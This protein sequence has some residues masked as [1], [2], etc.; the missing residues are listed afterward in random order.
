MRRWQK[1]YD[2]ISSKGCEAF[3]VSKP[4]NVRYLCGYRGDDSL[5]ILLEEGMYLFTDFRYLEDAEESCYGKCQVM[6][7]PQDR[8]TLGYVLDWLKDRSVGKV[9]FESRWTVYE[10]YEILNSKF[11]AIPI[12]DSVERLRKIKNEDEID[13]IRKAGEIALRGYRWLLDKISPGVSERELEIHLEA[14]LKEIGAEERAFPFIIA[15]GPNAAKPHARPSARKIAES[16]AVI[17]DFGVVWDGYHV[18]M[19]RTFIVGKPSS[20]LKEIYNA[21]RGAQEAVLERVKPGVRVSELHALAEKYLGKWGP[22]FKH[23]LGHGVGLEIHESPRISKS[24]EEILEEGMVITIEPGVY[25]RG[26][27]GV[28][29]EDTIVVRAEGAEILTPAPKEGII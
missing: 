14:F 7:I 27:L 3:L 6:E 10:T 25:L 1:V 22:Y 5:L 2:F 18:D 26:E 24:S 8:K 28:R 19:T 4:V 11:N 29:I 17:C 21:V 23:S 9:G 20:K 13:R 16:E 12:S 15:T